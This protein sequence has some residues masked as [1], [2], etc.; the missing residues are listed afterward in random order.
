MV[1]SFAGTIAHF[2]NDDWNLI[3]CLVDFHHMG[4]KEHAGAYAVKA[5][6]KSAA[7]QDGLKKINI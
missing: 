3:K 7:G 2:I 5:F 6:V 1:F 4:D